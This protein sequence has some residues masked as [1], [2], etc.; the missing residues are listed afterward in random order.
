MSATLLAPGATAFELL[1]NLLLPGF[2]K[3]VTRFCV[4]RFT[5]AAETLRMWVHSAC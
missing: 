4:E 2:Y 5:K 3:G 1:E